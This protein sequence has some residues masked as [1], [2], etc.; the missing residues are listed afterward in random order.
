MAKQL[1][2]SVSTMG[3]CS[4]YQADGLVQPFLLDC[5]AKHFVLCRTTLCSRVAQIKVSISP[6][7]AAKP[8]LGKIKL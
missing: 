8:Y 3:N 7:I 6:I 4:G 2:G 1:A 5:K